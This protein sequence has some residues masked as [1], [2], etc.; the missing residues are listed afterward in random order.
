[1]KQQQKEKT[2]FSPQAVDRAGVFR[3]NRPWN[4]FLMP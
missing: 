3:N 2:P 4:L 1:M